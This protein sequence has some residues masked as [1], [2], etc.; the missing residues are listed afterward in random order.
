MHIRPQDDLISRLGNR[1]LYR[2]PTVAVQFRMHEEIDRLDD[3]PCFSQTVVDIVKTVGMVLSIFVEEVV[4]FRAAAGMQKVMLPHLIIEDLKHFPV[5]VRVNPISHLQTQG[6]IAVDGDSC[7][8]KF[9]Q[10][11]PLYR[12]RCRHL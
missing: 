11:V 1:R 5:A 12:S 4:H 10:A 3:R 9:V 8:Q 2:D 7:G 6:F